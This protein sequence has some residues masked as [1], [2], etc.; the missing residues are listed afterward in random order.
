MTKEPI[1]MPLRQP[2]LL[3]RLGRSAGNWSRRAR[4]RAR[5]L[6]ELLRA[7]RTPEGRR[8]NVEPLLMVAAAGGL[9]LGLALGW[10]RRR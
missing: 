6:S 4:T 8:R 1:P 7:A 3:D 10:R 2:P 5:R 9:L